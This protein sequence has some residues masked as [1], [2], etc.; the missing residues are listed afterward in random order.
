MKHAESPEQ[1]HTFFAEALNARDVEALAALYTIDACL[2]PRKQD[3]AC[4]A[5]SI[6]KLLASYC[7]MKTTMEIKTRKAITVGD[8]ALIMSDW[9]MTG[10]A[11]DGRMIDAGGT[12]VEVARRGADGAWRYLIDLPHGI[13]N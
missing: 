11:A 6:R 10:T 1:L 5:A 7:D 8:T 3:A 9:R 12:S 13:E 2:A 4:G